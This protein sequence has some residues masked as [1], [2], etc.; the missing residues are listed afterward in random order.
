[1]GRYSTG[2]VWWI[3][4][5]Y[6]DS[7][8]LKRRPAI[9]L[10]DDTIAILALYV[11]T[12]NKVNNPYCILIEDWKEAGLPKESW[13][14]IDKIVNVSEWNMDCKIG[15]LSQKDFTKIIQL[16]K[17]ILTNTSHAFLLLA[18]KNTS[19]QYLQKYDDRWESWL[20][21]YIRGTEDNKDNVDR[22]VSR[23]LGVEVE[24]KYV[25]CAKHCKY[26]VSDEVYKIYNHKLY[27]CL[28]ESIPKNMV[29]E[30]FEIDGNKYRWMS[31]QEMESDERIME[32]ND[33]VV[34]F[35]KAK[36]S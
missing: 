27:K 12:K 31:V 4:F 36:C 24:T 14:R 6:S 22:C 20:F 18:I 8:E 5:P 13:T 16:T 17:E 3:H 26:S 1:M 15:E 28:L 10:D 33:D 7:E 34:A 11:T 23:L 35:V 29:N 30:T 25:T 32:I 21:P 19:G 9:V 2:D